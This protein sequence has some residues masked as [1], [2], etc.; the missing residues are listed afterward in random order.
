LDARCYAGRKKVSHRGRNGPKIPNLDAAAAADDDDNNDI[1]FYYNLNCS[2]VNV[3]SNI[4]G[5]QDDNLK[6]GTE[7][8]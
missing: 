4:W 3:P 1:L 6:S 7:N 2:A 8:T 5:E